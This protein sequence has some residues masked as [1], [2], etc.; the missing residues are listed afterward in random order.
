MNKW[1]LEKPQL[2]PIHSKEIFSRSRA[3]YGNARQFEASLNAEYRDR[4]RGRS[5]LRLAH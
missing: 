2:H 5:Q 4:L 3:E 1:E